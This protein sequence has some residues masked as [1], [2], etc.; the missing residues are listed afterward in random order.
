MDVEVERLQRLYQGQAEH[1]TALRTELDRVIKGVRELHY[2]RPDSVSAMYPEPLCNCDADWP[3][4]T[5][6][7]VYAADELSREEG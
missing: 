7:L 3:C 1:I 2:P 4:D 5:A 6:R